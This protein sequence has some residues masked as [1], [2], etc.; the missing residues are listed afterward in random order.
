M[1]AQPYLLSA[2]FV[3]TLARTAQTQPGSTSLWSNATFWT[4]VA[5]LAAATAA[6]FAWR[7]AKAARD[8]VCTQVWLE[9]MKLLDDDRFV[10]KRRKVFK[11]ERAVEAE[12]WS[13]RDDPAKVSLEEAM[14]VCRRMELFASLVKSG[15][16]PRWYDP[17]N[18]DDTFCKAWIVLGLLVLA[19][20]AQFGGKIPTEVRT[21]ERL[22]QWAAFKTRGRDALKRLGWPRDW[23]DKRVPRDAQVQALLEESTMT[24]ESVKPK[25]FPER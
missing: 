6:L 11:E 15:S 10:E 13:N 8:A 18:V 7:Q 23:W 12:E 1:I 4:A 2:T 9:A 5:A 14:D 17:V 25:E 22:P 24:A 3:A 16:F 21:R 20:E 19:R